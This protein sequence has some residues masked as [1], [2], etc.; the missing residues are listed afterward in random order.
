[1]KRTF[2]E[3]VDEV[4]SEAAEPVV[5]HDLVTDL[6]VESTA[7]PVEKSAL[8]MVREHVEKMFERARRLGPTSLVPK[9]AHIET[10]NCTRPAVAR[11]PRPNI[12]LALLAQPLIAKAVLGADDKP[13]RH[14]HTQDFYW[15]GDVRE[16]VDALFAAAIESVERTTPKVAKHDGRHEVD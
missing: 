12:P 2:S 4:I 3:M 6:A 7:L 5:V 10:S 14:P 1:V 11:A 15:V 16:S 13:V 8:D 9:A